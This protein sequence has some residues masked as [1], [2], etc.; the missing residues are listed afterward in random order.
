[1]ADFQEKNGW[2]FIRSTTY[3]QKQTKSD[4]FDDHYEQQFKYTTESTGI[5]KCITLKVV[6]QFNIIGATKYLTK[7]N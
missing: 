1:M 2:S 6:K 5:R 4:S 7:T 3:T